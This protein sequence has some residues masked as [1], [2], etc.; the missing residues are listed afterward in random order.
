[1]AGFFKPNVVIVGANDRRYF[2]ESK[3]T[4]KLKTGASEIY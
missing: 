3:W 2:R 4:R 1:M